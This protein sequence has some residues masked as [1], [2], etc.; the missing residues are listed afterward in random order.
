MD[1]K[2]VLSGEFRG[3]PEKKTPID[4]S[5]PPRQVSTA[6]DAVKKERWRRW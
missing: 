5:L 6:P 1:A 4:S 3:Q 2:K